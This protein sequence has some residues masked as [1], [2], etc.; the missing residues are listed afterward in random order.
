[1][2]QIEFG[3][4]ESKCLD[5]VLEKAAYG[6]VYLPDQSAELLGSREDSHR[7][8]N[9]RRRHQMYMSH[10]TDR[11]LFNLIRHHEYEFR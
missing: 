2:I 9:N 11:G 10:A 7:L 4:C 6:L 1:M 5:T 3:R 8:K